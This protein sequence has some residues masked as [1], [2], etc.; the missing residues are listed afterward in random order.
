MP[1]VVPTPEAVPLPKADPTA[2]DTLVDELVAVAVLKP[3]DAPIAEAVLA[4][5]ADAAP[6][7][8]A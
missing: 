3:A 1:A 8:A 4:P 7:P 2:F 5:I 6:E